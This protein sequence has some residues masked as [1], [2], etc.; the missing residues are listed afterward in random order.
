[1]PVS[2]MAD[3][4]ITF[5]GFDELEETLIKAL[6]M[7]DVRQVVKKN[8]VLM[9]QLAARLVPVLTG[10]LRRS[11]VIE[12]QD[13]GL[14]GFVAFWAHY[15]P[16][17]EYGTRWIYGKWYLKRAHEQAGKQFLADMEALTK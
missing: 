8:T 5:D 2:T 4:E 3:Y 6:D 14:T 13:S 16:Y 17:Q 15:A 9:N 1:M 11:E 12:F 10:Y 7:A